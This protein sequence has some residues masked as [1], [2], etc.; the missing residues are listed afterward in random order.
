MMKKIF[1]IMAIAVLFSGLTGCYL[2]AGNEKPDH[3]KPRSVDMTASNQ[4]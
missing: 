1:K 4:N 2:M 3:E